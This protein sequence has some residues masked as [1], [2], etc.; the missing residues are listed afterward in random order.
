MVLYLFIRIGISSSLSKNSFSF[1]FRHID[2]YITLIISWHQLGFKFYNGFVTFS[3][4][5]LDI[6]FLHFWFLNRLFKFIRQINRSQLKE[7][8]CRKQLRNEYLIK[9]RLHFDTYRSTIHKEFISSIGSCLFSQNINS[10]FLKDFI[11]IIFKCHIKRKQIFI[12]KSILKRYFHSHF[13]SI[14][15]TWFNRRTRWFRI[16]REFNSLES[17]RV[18]NKRMA[19]A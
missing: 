8:Y 14:R 10:I 12:I 7:F 6:L 16:F 9:W 15:C 1:S 18:L 13:Q 11:I 3:I 4:C 17:W 19:K 2:C 5:L